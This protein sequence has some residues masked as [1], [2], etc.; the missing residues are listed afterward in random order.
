MSHVTFLYFYSS[1]DM[2]VVYSCLVLSVLLSVPCV[3]L[4]SQIIVDELQ[5][6]EGERLDATALQEDGDS[7]RG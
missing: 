7:D 3:L 5:Q 4:V 6:N 2:D 1:A